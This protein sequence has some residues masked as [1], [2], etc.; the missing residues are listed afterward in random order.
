MLDVPYILL[1]P[2]K[3]KIKKPLDVNKISESFG[4]HFN[5]VENDSKEIDQKIQ[6]LVTI[7][8]RTVL[9]KN[10]IQKY[11]NRINAAF[12]N[13]VS[14]TDLVK[15][16][17]SQKEESTLSREELLDNLGK[18]LNNNEIDSN[19]SK[20]Y[21][22]KNAFQKFLICVIGIILIAT[23][24]AMIIMPAPPS[25]ELFTVFYFN[26]NDGVTIMDLVSLLIILSGVF[27]FVLNLNKK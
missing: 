24:F 13:T 22:R 6:E 25:F 11:Q 15:P 1:I 4:Y 10:Q 17:T 21:L 9:N 23:G 20:R 7:L 12:Q 14:S 18:L 8:D 3:V 27:L 2:E 26:A 19:V 5:D 16:F